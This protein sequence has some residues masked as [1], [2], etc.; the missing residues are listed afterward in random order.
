MEWI[1]QTLQWYGILFILG[2]VFTP[3]ARFLFPNSPDRGYPFAKVLG[4]IAI[5]YSVFV[6]GILHVAQFTSLTLYFLL[7][8]GAIGNYFIFKKTSAPKHPINWLVIVCEEILFLAALMALAYMRGQEPSIHGL[9]KF[10]DYGFMM[11][12]LRSQYFPPADMWFAPLPINYYYFGHLSGSVL[13]RLSGT[14]PAVGYNL[15]L[16]T[17]FAL[18]ITQA[19]SLSVMM[20]SK[21]HHILLGRILSTIKLLVFGLLGAALVNT[22]GNLHTI[23]LFTR[24]YPNENP[25]P[26]WTILS[27]YTPEKYWYPNATRFIPFTIHEFPSYSY[28]VAD[29]HGHVYD[30]PFVLL[31]LA[32]LYAFFMKVKEYRAAAGTK[33]PTRRGKQPVASF[34]PLRSLR[35]LPF[36]IPYSILFGFM[37]SVHYMTNAFDGPIYLLL[38]GVTLLVLF[39]VSAKLIGAVGVIVVSF[40]LFSLPFSVFFKP[41]ASGIGV[42]CAPGF[43]TSL[44]NLGPFLFEKGNCQVSPPWMLFVL[45]G[46]Y[47][48]TFSLFAYIL[49]RSKEHN[50]WS[51]DIV[52][53]IWFGV[54]FFLI[55]VPEFFYIKDIYPQHF[56]ANTMFKMGYQAFIMMSLASLYVFY[57]ISLI[58]EKSKY[59]LKGIYLVFFTLI[60]IYPFYS[61]PSYYGSMTRTPSLDGSAWIAVSYPQDKEIIDYLN[62]RIK[63]QPVVLEAQGDSYTDY[64]RISSFTGLPTIAGWWVHQWLWRGTADA[65][66]NRIPD[67]VDIYESADLERTR[68]L[69][70][71]YNVEYV[72][73]SELEREKYKNINE[74][75]FEQIGKKIFTSTNGLGA[76]YQVK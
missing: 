1:G 42:N 63:G 41:F 14:A 57:R 53:L 31:T 48:L 75:K 59:I 70:K 28:V 55:T 72:V 50:K 17:I 30:I 71:K 52:P 58:Q 24:G 27:W 43:L 12:I 54:G 40:V 73:V 60:F 29:L 39:K 62:T 26:F 11:S 18:G 36:L 35:E 22:V 25:V 66:G 51:P 37:I 34:A 13:I 61:V 67:I 9:E 69:I 65:V 21:A 20:V 33:K 7:T 47:L 19:F 16:A 64:E 44:G 15:V 38:V 3:T 23:Y 5:T 68:A 10:M 56:R 4:I 6:A 8:L 49:Y 74:K 32:L 46:F 2:V 76:L 45:W